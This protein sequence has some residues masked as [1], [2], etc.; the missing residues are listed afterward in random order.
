MQPIQLIAM[1]MDGTLLNHAQQIPEE[2][3]LALRE[4]SARGIHIAICSGRTARD[5]SFFAS[6]AGFDD[7]AILG[8]NGACCLEKPHGKPYAVHTIMPAHAQRVADTLLNQN[9]TFACFQPERVVVVQQN[10]QVPKRNWGTYVA[11]E[12]S[13]AYSYGAE[14]LIRHLPEGACKFVYIDR[15]LDPRIER[16]RGL[17]GGIG[18]LD[19]TSSWANNLEIMPAGVTKGAALRELA[20]K[21]RVPQEGVM[22]LGD[23]DNDLTMIEFAGYG[24]AMGNA[25]EKVK[26]AARFVTLTNAENGVAAAIR[27]FALSAVY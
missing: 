24:I 13:D 17:L 9:V 26:R 10:D 14:A 18:G 21:L 27:R 20:A 8:L 5:A 19:V 11:R 16:I 23:Y 4:A 15:D 7:C 2:N 22:A 6:D 1:D 12:K 25:S 3:R